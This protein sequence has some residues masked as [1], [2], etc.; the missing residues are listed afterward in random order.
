MVKYKYL[1]MLKNEV[2]LQMFTLLP[3]DTQILVTTVYG[4]K[5]NLLA[6][7]HLVAVIFLGQLS[8]GRLDDATT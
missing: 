7:N 6:A 5:I 3:L 1:H 4:L 2:K 8:E